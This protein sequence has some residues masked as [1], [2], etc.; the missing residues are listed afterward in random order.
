MVNH[1]LSVPDVSLLL[2]SLACWATACATGALLAD[3]PGKASRSNLE[4]FWGLGALIAIAVVR[5]LPH[6]MDPAGNE[7][8]HTFAKTVND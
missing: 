2:L 6:S 3:L 4:P 5:V 8:L 1:E 7:C